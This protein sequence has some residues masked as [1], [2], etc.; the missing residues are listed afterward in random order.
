MTELLISVRNP[1]EALT[2]LEGGADWIDVKEPDNGAL[3]KA[4]NET[5]VAVANA[6]PLNTKLSAAL[7]EASEFK[8]ENRDDRPVATAKE[9]DAH[10][11]V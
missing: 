2:A 1:S 7:G 5:L 6:L 9:V 10:F 4:S 3:G 11:G 8:F